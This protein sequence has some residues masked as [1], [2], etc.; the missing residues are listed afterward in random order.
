MLRLIDRREEHHGQAFNLARALEIGGR[1]L[2]NSDASDIEVKDRRRRTM[3]TS[4]AARRVS[5]ARFV[6]HILRIGRGRP[7][8]SDPN[9]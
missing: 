2:V 3:I 4:R 7:E 9:P 5:N 1:V 6:H 8:Q